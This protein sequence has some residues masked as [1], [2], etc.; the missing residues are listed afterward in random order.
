MLPWSRKLHR[1]DHPLVNAAGVAL[2]L[3]AVACGV[4]GQARADGDPPTTPF[5]RLDLGMHGAEINSL[6]TDARGELIA[7]ASDDK[8]VRLWRAADGSLVATLRIPIVDGAE[9]QL[10]AVAIAPDGKRVLAAG[11][12]G[13]SFGPGFALYLFDV[14]KQALIGRLPGLPQAIMDIAYAPSG[15]AFVLGFAKTAGIRLYSASGALTAEDGGYGDRVSAIGF[16]ADGRFAVSSYDGQIRLYDAA[17]KRLAAAKAPGGARPSSVAFSPDGKSLAVGYD[18]A[19][20]VDILAADTLSPKLS[21]NVAD[22]DN[23][24][25]STVAWTGD[26]KAATLYA[27][28]RPRNHEG[29]IVVRRW[30]NGGAGV[31]SDIAVGRDLVTRLVPLPSGALAFATADPAWGVIDARGQVAFRR[32]SVTDDF[33]VMS[34]RRFDV[35]PDA[36]TVEFAPAAPGHPVLRFDFR[37]RHLTRLSA[38]EAAARRY[39]PKRPAVPVTGLNTST[40]AVAGTK[41]ELR[42]LELA[43]SVVALPDRILVGTDYNL[44]SFDRS[45]QEISAPQAVPGA[46]WALTATDNGRIAVAALGD[47]TLRWYG[48]AAAKTPAPIVTMFVHGDGQRWVAWTQD[49]FFDHA[50]IGGKEL[51]G[52]Q[53]NRGKGEAPEWVGFAQLYRAFYAPDLVLGRLIGTAANA[54]QQRIAAIG[55]VRSLLHSGGMPQ[56]AVEAYCI[57]ASGQSSCTPIDL[58][59]TMKIAPVPP[60]AASPDYVNVVFPPGTG[61]ITLRYKVIDRGAGI[62]PIDLFLN[63]RNA[64]REAAADVAKDLHPITGEKN[65]LAFEGE[66]QVRL[67]DGVNRIELRVYDKAEKTYAV[68]STVSFLAPAKVAAAT[69]PK[70]ALPRLFILAAGIDRYRPPAPALD[71]AVTDSKSFVAAVTQ[72]AQS[73]YRDITAYELYDEQATVAGIDKALDDIAA[74]AT[75]D[76]MLLV[77]LSGHGEQ[78]NNEY[79]FIPQE[80]TMKDSDSDD[81]VDQEIAHQ[82]F[83]GEDLVTH[84][85]KIAAKNGFLFLDTCH[86]GAIHLD[87]GPARINQ[88]S[89]RYILVA[90]QRIQSAL[91]SYDGKNGVFAYA[92]LEGLKGKGRQNAAKPVDNIDLGFYVADRVTEL[93]KEKNYDQSS[94]FKI[95]AEDARRFPISSPSP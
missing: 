14:D 75:P 38:A 88:E 15:G 30:S 53:L 78:V 80:F 40:L 77:Y 60:D 70:P 43:R 87:T 65:G 28:G 20:R 5:L 42:G 41:I 50:D 13:F 29:S 76:D 44:R 82:G 94:S 47:G 52:Y 6:A 22:L 91:D 27:G 35:S 68:S 85:G 62:G 37:S 36:L 25:L 86:A 33:R 19:R 10:N 1:A 9:G 64:G 95:S 81:E 26:D 8:T 56:V 12:T 69:A 83:S 72:G 21:P 71:L 31:A 54:T 90:S 74:Q 61:E 93:A 57:A 84:L 24:A 48:L 4:T 67:D 63:D 45:G 92:V 18:D 34:E 51:V 55:D 11:S 79:Y 23:G 66:R 7:T 46:V 3:I 59:A 39:A 17:G 73:L 16:A 2:L 49:G 32:G 89:G 58:G